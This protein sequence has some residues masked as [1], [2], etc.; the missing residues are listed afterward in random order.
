MYAD[1]KNALPSAKG[2]RVCVMKSPEHCPN[3]PGETW[4][5]LVDRNPGG[6]REFVQ[7]CRVRL[8][9]PSAATALPGMTDRPGRLRAPGGLPAAGPASCEAATASCRPLILPFRRQYHPNT[10]S[11][12][13]LCNLPPFP[14]LCHNRGH[15]KH[16]IEKPDRRRTRQHDPGT[17]PSPPV[18]GRVRRPCRRPL[19]EVCH[20]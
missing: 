6:H 1:G 12:P 17:P 11:I 5:R 19:S 14:P 13:P 15:E 9:H 8:L 18:F 2:G 20:A 3:G 7:R 10:S 16:R 4:I